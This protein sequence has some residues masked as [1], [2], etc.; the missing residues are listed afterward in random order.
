MG[1]RL[2]GIW[3]GDAWTLWQLTGCHSLRIQAVAAY[4][5]SFDYFIPGIVVIVVV[6]VIVVVTSLVATSYDEVR[7]HRT[8]SNNS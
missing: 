5:N 4:I 1:I 7:G 8:D 2:V 3:R 6:I